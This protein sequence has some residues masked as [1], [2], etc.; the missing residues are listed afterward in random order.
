MRLTSILI[1]GVFALTA[2]AQSSAS[3]TTATAATGT[4]SSPAATDTS[5]VYQC[6]NA[7]E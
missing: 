7:C 2:S 4:D 1:A 6:L 3:Q 5:A